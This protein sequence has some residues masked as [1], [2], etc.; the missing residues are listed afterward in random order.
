MPTA[1]RVPTALQPR[2][3]HKADATA[4]LTARDA[5]ANNVPVLA[6]MGH[7]NAGKSSVVATLTENDRIAID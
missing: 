4:K 6:I 3:A 2:A 5:A 7:P 1:S